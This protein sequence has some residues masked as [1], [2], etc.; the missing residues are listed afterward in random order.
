MS[1][2]LFNGVIIGPFL[3]AALKY[4]KFV[5]PGIMVSV[6]YMDPGNYSTSV[7]A[8]SS[9]EYK[10][11]VAVFVSNLFAVL[12][13]CLCIKVG[14]V[15]GLD[16]AQN[17]RLHLPRWLNLTVYVFTEIAIV[18]TDLAEVVGSAIALNILFGIPLELGIVLTVV[19]VLIVLVA[20][21]SDGTTRQLRYF[22]LFVSALVF[23]TCVCFAILLQKVEIADVGAVFKGF[24]PLSSDILEKKAIYLSLG[25]LGATV[26][27]HSLYLGSALVQPRLR[28]YDIKHGNYEPFEGEQNGG[29]SRMITYRPS[30]NALDYCLKMSYWELIAS[31]FFIALF[32]NSSILIVAGAS[33]YG[34]PDAADADLLTIYDMLTGYVS[35]TA[36]LLF[37]LAMLFSGQSAGI[38]C[39][40]SGQIVSEGFI[41]WKVKPWV[42]RII[43]RLICII[44]CLGMVL[45]VGR[46]GIAQ[47]LNG[48]QVLLSLIL[49]IV[50]APLIYFSCSHEIMRVRV[51]KVPIENR[52]TEHDSIDEQTNLLPQSK[53]YSG[54]E[55]LDYTNGVI[56]SA[57]SLL[58]WGS[59]SCLNFYLIIQFM[60]GEDIDF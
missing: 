31:L 13:Q 26:M 41:H 30:L 48:S 36:G 21:K 3:Q 23:A 15:T 43:T 46:K 37:A 17:C 14:S 12:L 1:S 50:S 25:I 52:E 42:R 19:E 38:I 2:G 45:F 28:D 40:M 51:N 59:I 16:L 9:Y 10:L 57:L 18:A 53:T 8:G 39:T 27:P 5:G 24:A 34:K 32:V 60:R 6:A 35:P 11:L 55:Y 44:P 47:I 20:Y 33:L 54:A 4:A 56:L 29:P 58:T 7:A 22:E 49:P